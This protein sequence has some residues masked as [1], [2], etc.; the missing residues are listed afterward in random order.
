MLGFIVFGLVV[1]ALARLIA[2]GPHRVGLLITLALGLIGS[3]IGG[4]V[5]TALGR[6]DI[7]EL[8]LV[9]SIVAIASA[10]VLLAVM[11]GGS[12]SRRTSRRPARR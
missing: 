5:A 12:R 3:V 2:P 8:N 1:G 6:G 10:A 4:T 7:L 11:E 9:G